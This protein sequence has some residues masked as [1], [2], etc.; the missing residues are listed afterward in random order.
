MVGSEFVQVNVPPMGVLVYADAATFPPLQ[1]VMFAG[2][3]TV[4]LGLIVIV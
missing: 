3:V 4:G 2:T 1:T